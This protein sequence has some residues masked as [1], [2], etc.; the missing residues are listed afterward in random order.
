MGTALT[1]DPSPRGEG[2]SPH[3]QPA[4][5]NTKPSVGT[6]RVR[7][8]HRIALT[9]RPPLPEARGE[10]RGAIFPLGSVEVIAFLLFL[11]HKIITEYEKRGA[12]Y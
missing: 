12:N 9:P 10:T 3:H 8:L 1:P 11:R 5:K 7:P 2:R 4:K 6:H